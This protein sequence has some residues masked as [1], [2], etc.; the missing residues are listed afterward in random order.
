M[1][2]KVSYRKISGPDGL[3]ANLKPFKGNTMSAEF[4]GDTY[5]VY[6]YWTPI[7]WAYADGRR[8]F[9][10]TRYSVTTSKHQGYTQA[11]LGYNHKVG[12]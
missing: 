5:V 1:T 12:V 6:S 4:E 9:D 2:A 8:E 11:W 3:L 10:E 7:A